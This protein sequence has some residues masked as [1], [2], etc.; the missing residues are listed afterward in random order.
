MRPLQVA[1][2]EAVQAN[3][4]R[5]QQQVKSGSVTCVTSSVSLCLTPLAQGSAVLQVLH[6]G[7]GAHDDHARLD[8]EPAAV[9][10]QRRQ[11][12]ALAVKHCSSMV[13]TPLESSKAIVNSANQAAPELSA[14]A[15]GRKVYV[16]FIQL[17]R[18]L[19]LLHYKAPPP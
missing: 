3:V 5:R 6:A 9:P 12:R 14:D 19:L 10:R 1:C 2:H 11:G 8:A 17:G 16:S 15:I 13:Q 4:P 7:N 18:R